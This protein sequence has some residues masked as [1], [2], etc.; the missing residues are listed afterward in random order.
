VTTPDYAVAMEQTCR[1]DLDWFFDQWAYGIG[2]PRVTFQRYW[3][4]AAGALHVTVSQTQP[5]DSLHPLFRFP[6]TLRVITRDSVV[7]QEIMVSKASETFTVPLPSEP[8]SFRFD[9]GGWLLG[10]VA[11]DLSTAELADMATHDLDVRGRDWA[12]RQ[13]AMT[14]DAAAQAAR[15]MVVLN[16]HVAA[17]RELALAAMRA[18]SSAATLAVL[19]SA[20]RD[21]DGSV[22][23]AALSDLARLDSTDAVAPA[24]RMYPTDPSDAT[25]QSALAVIAHA[26]GAEALDLL[27]AASAPGQPLGIR[28]TAL[29]FLARIHDPRAL[30]ALE[31][32]TASSEDR[33]LRT[34][35]LNTLVASGDSARAALVALRLVADPDPLFAVAAVRAAARAGGVAARAQLQQALPHESRVFVRQAI[36]QALAPADAG[37]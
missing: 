26:Q 30:D 25:R 18:D 7:R 22:R 28:F 23:G 16:E 35:G 33:N 14:H 36:R 2:Y 9:E 13:L 17:L 27:I 34:A 19:R 6:V 4:A 5:V 11:G 1:C 20:L 24:M 12:L 10:T 32:L 29:T 37:H 21:P 3:D 8:R 31:A 15:R